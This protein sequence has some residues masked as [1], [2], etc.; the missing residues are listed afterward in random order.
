[1][2]HV[3]PVS[4]PSPSVSAVLTTASPASVMSAAPTRVSAAFSALSVSA[5]WNRSRFAIFTPTAASVLASPVVMVISQSVI[6]PVSGS[7]A[8]CPR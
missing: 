5:R 4:P 2:D 7:V 3:L 1:V 8:R 6:S